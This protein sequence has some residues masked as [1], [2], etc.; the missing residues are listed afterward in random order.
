MSK[1][2]ILM[3]VVLAAVFIL[4]A[5]AP[6]EAHFT[7]GCKAHWTGCKRHVVK[8]FNARLNRMAWCESRY[9]WHIEGRYSG[10]LQFSYDTW[11]RAG[12]HGTAGSNTVLEQKYRA[13]VWS[14][15]IGWNW[16]STAGWPVCG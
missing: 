10:G 7:R 8:P 2:R 16:H 1:M 11:R 12:G 6:T 9:H 3:A 14:S 4:I 15:M 5:T 13:V